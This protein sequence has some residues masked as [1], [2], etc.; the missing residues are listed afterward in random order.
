MKAM[1][2][3]MKAVGDQFK[4]GS[5]DLAVIKVQAAK[6]DAGAK[7]L[8]TWFPVGSGPAPGVKTE[9]LPLIW[10]DTAGFAAKQHAFAL[11]AAKFDTAA[12][13]GDQAALLPAAKSVGAACKSCHDTYKAK[14]KA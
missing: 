5:P 4:S 12:Q 14:D 11:A 10:T 3:A 9:A 2:A 13:T 7:A 1:G 6:I 8:P